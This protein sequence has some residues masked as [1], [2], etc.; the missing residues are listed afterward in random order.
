MVEPTVGLTTAPKPNSAVA[1]PI[2]SRGQV[3][4][5]IACDVDI[6]PPPASPCN[7]LNTTSSAKL[8]ALPHKKEATVNTII[9]V[10]KYC[11]RPKRLPNQPDIGNI[12]T[13]AT[14]YPV[15]TQATSS[16]VAPRLPCI[17]GRDTFT[18]V[19]SISSSNEATIT[20]IVM[21]HFLKPVSAIIISL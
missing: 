16:R 13:F 5:K 14:A 10:I 2:C 3:S 4:T 8:V 1:V 7:I 20:V 6:K 15:T 9:D 18:I 11:L 17:T 21:I 19:V 12:I